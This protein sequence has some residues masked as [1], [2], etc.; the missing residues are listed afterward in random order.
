[1]L[2]AL[3]RTYLPRYRKPIAAIVI[4]QLFGALAAL[5]LPSLNADIIDN[6][7]TQ[8]DIP[9]IIRIGGIMLAVAALQITCSITAVYFAAHT[10]TSLGA[11]LRRDVFHQVNQFSAREMGVF[12]A[13]SLITRNTNDVLQ[14]QTLV[15]MSFTL[16]VMAPIMGVG[17]IIMA[18]REDLRLSWLIAVSVPALALSMGIIIARMIPGYRLMQIKIDAVNRVLRE[19]ITGARVVRAFVREP[20]ETRRFATANNELTDTALRVGRLMAFAFPIVMLIMNVSSVGVIWFGGIEIDEGRMQVGSLTAMLSYLILIL[21]SIMMVT[22][23]AS[24]VPRAAVCA[25]RIHDVLSTESSIV[26][27]PK[28]TADMP[29]PGIVEFRGATFCYP[30]AEKPVIHNI[31]FTVTP[32]TT[33]AIIGATGSGKSTVLNLIPRLIDCTDGAV[34]VGG[35]DV[36]NLDPHLLRSNIG[37][38]PQRA[39]LFSGTIATNLRYGRPDATDEELWDALTVAQAANFVRAMP[40]G[41][42]SPVSQG[43]TTVSGGQR[44]RLAI[45]RALVRAPQ[46]YLFDDSF[47]ALD[48]ATDA[49]LRAALKPRTTNSAVILVGQRIATI[50]DADQIVVLDGGAVV[51]TG[52]HDYL[53]ATCAE[54]RETVDSQMIVEGNR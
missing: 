5:L 20:W 36:K 50:R 3:L 22:F 30:G 18:L 52:K 38:V 31:T 47:S 13:P 37:Y 17:G 48:V 42:D 1:M 2:I 32:G 34:L 26:T 39:F 6:G 49:R 46:I 19:Q 10:A 35:V 40:L 21:M 7:V 54:Y 25:E 4:L 41:L 16:L 51:G 24:Q 11:D 43:G 15:L 9:Y 33:T 12:G 8:G 14:V 29:T 28:P 23:M 45:A 53:V 44:Q 27:S